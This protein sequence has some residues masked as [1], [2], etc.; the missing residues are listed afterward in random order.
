MSRSEAQR[1]AVLLACASF[2]W[3]AGCGP[4]PRPAARSA[5]FSEPESAAPRPLAAPAPQPV[6]LVIVEEHR[7]GVRIAPPAPEVPE[8][9][10]DVPYMAEALVDDD[11]SEPEGA[12]SERSRERDALLDEMFAR[13]EANDA[14]RD[15]ASR[16]A[17]G[18]TSQAE[19]E[20]LMDAVR[21][22]VLGHVWTCLPPPGS[23]RRATVLLR[24]DP[25][26]PRRNV[27][28]LLMEHGWT[29]LTGHV[30]YGDGDRGLLPGAEERFDVTLEGPVAMKPGPNGAEVMYDETSMRFFLRNVGPG[31]MTM[32]FAPMGRGR[33]S[34]VERDCRATPMERP[35]SRSR[36][37]QEQ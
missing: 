20:R 8:P 15:V 11:H 36:S 30:M 3:A 31:E 26:E 16:T 12:N 33:M 25:R 34:G 32:R 7:P 18:G 27:D 2:G 24:L 37:R 6:P 1:I 9:A 13:A 4:S 23:R 29:L 22:H 14:R 35:R 10:D 21:A 28:L 17:N 19:H 5:D